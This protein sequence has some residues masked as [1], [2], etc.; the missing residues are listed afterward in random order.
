MWVPVQ[1]VAGGGGPK[2][3]F[4]KTQEYTKKA[5]SELNPEFDKIFITETNLL[6]TN[7]T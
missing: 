2:F 3:S 4:W 7:K 5:K 6:L 1:I